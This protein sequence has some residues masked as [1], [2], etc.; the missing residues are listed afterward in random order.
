MSGRLNIWIRHHYFLNFFYLHNWVIL[1][2]LYLILVVFIKKL[3]LEAKNPELILMSLISRGCSRQ[4][5]V[6]QASPHEPIIAI[7]YVRSPL[8]ANDDQLRL[9]KVFISRK[10]INFKILLLYISRIPFGVVMCHRFINTEQLNGRR[11]KIIKE[12]QPEI[13]R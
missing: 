3:I 8:K 11:R 7:I 1:W 9:F 13:Q 2:S 5:T 12:Q 10:K 4:W 6:S